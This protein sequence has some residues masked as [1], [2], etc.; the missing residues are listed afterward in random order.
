MKTKKIHRNGRLLPRASQSAR[1]IPSRTNTFY[2]VGIGASAG[3][4]D[5]F[6]QSL[7]PLPMDTGMAFVLVQ[8]LAPGH[9]SMLTDILGRET[10]MPVYEVKDNMAVKPNHV[11][12]IPP[13]VQ[14]SIERG[15]LH[16]AARKKTLDNPMPIDHFLR[17]LAEDKGPQAIAVILSGADSDGSL[18]LKTIKQRGGVTFAQDPAVAKFDTMPAAAVKTGLVDF[19]L[20]ADQIARELVKIASHPQAHPPTR[21]SAGESV[22]DGNG[23]LADIYSILTID[24]GVDFTHYKQTTLKRRIQRRMLLHRSGTLKDYIELLKNNP[25]EAAALYDDLLIHVTSFFRDT[26]VFDSLKKKVFP[27]LNKNRSPNDMIRIWVPGCSTGEEVYSIAISL[28]EHLGKSAAQTPIQI[29]ATD[30]SET[31]LKKA[32]AGIY[33]ESSMATVSVER[34]RR[35]FLPLAGGQFEVNKSVRNL[36]VFSK[37]NVAKD[38]PFSK[39][40]LISCRNVLIYLDSVLQKTVLPI[41]H[42][43]LKPSGLLLLGKSE[44]LGV[45]PDLFEAWDR[46]AK[47]YSKTATPVKPH[48]FFSTTDYPIEASA[49]ILH[50]NLDHGKSSNMLKEADRYVLEKFAPAGVVIDAAMNIVQFRGDIGQYMEL[51]P[52]TASFHLFKLLKEGLLLEL[53]PLIK[54]AKIENVSIKRAVSRVTHGGQI[55][56]MTLE[57]VPL[58]QA[59]VHEPHF[60]ILFTETPS[61]MPPAGKPGRPS[62][63]PA[64][65]SAL[66]TAALEHSRLKKELAGT[67]HYLQSV[68]DEHERVNEELQSA[69]EESLSSNEEFQ[70]T[71]EELETAKE[72]LQA[73]NEETTTLNDDLNNRNLEL[74]RLNNDM[75]NLEFSV[76]IPTV[77][78][79]KDHQIRRLTSA[80]ERVLKMSRADI[81]RS[82]L[83]L[84][85]TILGPDLKEIITTVLDTS[86]VQEREIQ[87]FLGHWY[88][89][90]ILPYKT[91][92][93]FVD[94]VV[95]TLSDIQLAKDQ[96]ATA[97]AWTADLEARVAERTKE[98]AKSQSALL[99]SE[100]LEAIGRLAGGVAHDFNNLMTGIL[101]MSQN[102]RKQ[103]GNDSPHCDDLEEVIDAAKKA[104]AVTK[105]LLAFG[106][107]QVFDPQVMNINNVIT[108]MTKLLEKLLG[109][110]IDLVTVL[111]P[112]LGNVSIDQSSI[113]QVILNLGL[114]AR[115]SMPKGGKITLRTA[116]SEIT[117]NDGVQLIPM[118]PGL[119]VALT[120]TDEGEGMSPETIEHLFE[121][122]FTTKTEG[123]GT[124]LGLATVYGI[125]KQSSGGISLKSALGKGTS[126]TVYLPHLGKNSNNESLAPQSQEVRGGSE[127]ILV[128]EDESI[129]RKVLVRELRGKGYTVLH[130]SNGKEAARISKEHEEPIHLLLTDVIMPGMNG[131]ELAE[132]MVRKRPGL[133]VLYMSGYDQEIIAQRG[134]LEPGVAF[135]EKSF[136]SEGLCQK[137][138]E[139]LD[140]AQKMGIP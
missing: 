106:R 116:Q 97:A 113:E 75:L 137:V 60:L 14:M 21:D 77:I 19:V 98:L 4:L 44:S 34:R 73:T 65:I 104:M 15:I 96:Q 127:T 90:R 100:K 94:G 7:R 25:T 112:H 45:I 134:V 9:R 50:E 81:G 140:A 119:Y 3:G 10:R 18:A 128:T 58:Q 71:N 11:Y 35:F 133:A 31:V 86:E 105:Q 110:D 125:I 84:R 66:K 118:V 51:V 8:H 22:S 46:K 27:H 115:D 87:D 2:I 99:Q 56:K 68:I 95:L 64:N 55:K 53:G 36:C 26:Q 54:K 138:R 57:V 93:G 122:F 40:D 37:Q 132:L 85:L 126:F 103:L 29:F 32:R 130:A 62:R 101:G 23:E 74:L 43:A 70:S 30:I 111:D 135:I 47:I 38:P 108:N 28:L 24:R 61:V 13:N 41:F 80:A 123:K 6:T 82:I 69:N 89:M 83:D 136:S 131:R 78:L 139:V 52:G 48:V 17:S 42:F 129:V 72:E 120:V 20:P 88:S 92:D 39:L 67:K 121:P 114:N 49:R 79:G 5:A 16:L 107:R 117:E 33:T 1:P 12:V 102:V 91:L 59:P 109:A 124:G 76:N 63:A